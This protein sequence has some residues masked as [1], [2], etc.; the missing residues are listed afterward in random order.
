M[1]KL[2]TSYLG[3]KLVGVCGPTISSNL[4]VYKGREMAPTL[5]DV[6]SSDLMI[7]HCTALSDKLKGEMTLITCQTGPAGLEDCQDNQA[8]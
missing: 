2:V 1:N 8:D 7:P 6:I 4:K 5:R 3:G